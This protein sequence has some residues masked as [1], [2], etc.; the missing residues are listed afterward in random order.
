MEDY[1][2][3]VP[4]TISALAVFNEWVESFCLS[5]NIIEYKEDKNK[6]KEI[7]DLE[8]QELLSL[9]AE[10]CIAYAICLMNYA[11]ILQK[12][13]DILSTQKNWSVEALNFLMSKYWQDYSTW[14]PA[15]I[16]RQAIIRENSYAISVEK[17]KLR[18][19]AGIQL[20]SETCKDIKKRVGLLQDLGKVKGFNK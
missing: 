15:E 17:N 14:M 9:S 7:L 11:G 19:E 2:S 6:Y 8:Y 13:L 3:N 1:N 12:K 4:E 16:K 5:Q 18:I 20:L 10:E